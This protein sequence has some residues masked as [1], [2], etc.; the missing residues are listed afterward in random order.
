[1]ELLL[2]AL[3]LVS[4]TIAHDLYVMPVRFVLK[5][6]ALITVGLHNGDSF[7]ESEVSPV[8]ERVRD[9]KLLSAEGTSEVG[10][11]HV[12]GKAVEGEV[13][14]P[15]AGSYVLIARTV[16]NSFQ[17]GAREFE[18]YLKE[19]GLQSILDWRHQHGESGRPGRERYSK[20]AKALLMA[21]NGNEFHTRPVGLT[22]EIVPEVSPYDL[23]AGADFPVRVLLSGEPAPDLQ[24][25]TAWAGAGAPTRTVIAGRTDKNGRIVIPRL[26]AGKW[27]I[28][29]V[30]MERCMEP[31]VA[32]WESFWTSLTVQ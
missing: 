8:L 20:Y 5:G 7:P 10:N 26:S 30:Y 32:D 2:A 13:G 6:G 3:L 4:A 9:M 12:A 15:R 27:R 17:L 11:L 23:K 28:H 22:I 21:G 25:E 16:P 18:T 14:I 31:R 29:S 1:M 19:E 24:V